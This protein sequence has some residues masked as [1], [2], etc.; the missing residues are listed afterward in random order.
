MKK[1]VSF[2][3]A[4]LVSI[5]ELNVRSGIGTGFAVTRK[6]NAND[7]I[8]VYEEKNGWVRISENEWVSGKYVK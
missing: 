7:P 8:T 3:Y 2:P 4:A 5:N 1:A 6:V